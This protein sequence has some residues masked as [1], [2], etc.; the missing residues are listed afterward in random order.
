MSI[1]LLLVVNIGVDTAED[2]PSKVSLQNEPSCSKQEYHMEA[3][4]GL[5]LDAMRRE[6]QNKLRDN[7]MRRI[8][9][10]ASTFGP[11]K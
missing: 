5:R 10:M 8:E 6:E 2:Q 4:E 3:V 1:G 7:V 11:P 9:S